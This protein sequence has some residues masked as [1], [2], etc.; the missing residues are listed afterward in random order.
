MPGT[1][2]AENLKHPRRRSTQRRLAAL[3]EARTLLLAIANDDCNLLLTYRQVYGIYQTSSGM[4]EELK[5]LFRLPGISIDSISLNDQVRSAIKG[6]AAQ[7]LQE[8]PGIARSS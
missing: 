7:W 6:A 2:R 3:G 8:N 5:P 4:V 1:S